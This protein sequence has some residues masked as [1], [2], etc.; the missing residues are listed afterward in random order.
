MKT[1]LLLRHAKS[2]WNNQGLTDFD[3]PLNERGNRQAIQMGKKILSLGDLPEL[4]IHSTAKRTSETTKII[5]KEMGIAADRIKQDQS[6]YLSS[7]NNLL[8]VI[9]S[10]PDS[11]NCIM[12]V[13]HN[14]GITDLSN[15]LTQN[16][17]D[18]IP[19]CGAVKIDAF[20]DSWQEI[21]RGI[22]SQKYFI[23]PKMFDF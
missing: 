19:T 1:I 9:D 14:P 7:Y 23:Y 17:I 16:Y 18:N 5:S 22:G 6:M 4:I 3:R 13:G 12:L 8:S 2:S 10:I 20:V 21:A 11:I 15:Y